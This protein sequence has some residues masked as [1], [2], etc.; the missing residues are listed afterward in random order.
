MC[1]APAVAGEMSTWVCS[2]TVG[3]LASLGEISSAVVCGYNT[4]VTVSKAGKNV[5]SYASIPS[6]FS[7]LSHTSAAATKLLTRLV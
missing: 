1:S 4:L 7:L 6:V 5:P 3:S 2:V